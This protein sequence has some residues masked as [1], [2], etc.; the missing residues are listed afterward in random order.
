[1]RSALRAAICL[2]E[3]TDFAFRAVCVLYCYLLI[4]THYSPRLVFVDNTVTCSVVISVD[5]QFGHV[6]ILPSMTLRHRLQQ[7][8]SSVDVLGFG[9]LH[10]IFLVDRDRLCDNLVGITVWACLF[11]ALK[12]NEA[13]CAAIQCIRHLG[14][15]ITSPDL[16]TSVLLCRIEITR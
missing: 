6:L 13:P 5:P 15:H 7:L 9:T 1:M 4:L 2:T 12:N 14:C 11:R 8:I 10:L 16:Y 3:N